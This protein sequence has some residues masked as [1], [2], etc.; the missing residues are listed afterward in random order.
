M[1]IEPHVSTDWQPG[2]LAL[3]IKV[4]PW[5]NPETKTP[6][7]RPIKGGQFC[8]V[9]GLF[10][11]SVYRTGF[12]LILKEDPRRA[13]NGNRVNYASDRFVKVT[14]EAEDAFDRQVIRDSV[15]A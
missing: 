13:V 5:T 4:G 6:I 11:D 12:G 2:D 14:P 1:S 15:P 8:T 9:E 7:N 10:P 3:C